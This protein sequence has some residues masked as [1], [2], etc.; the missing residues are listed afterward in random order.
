MV[1]KLIRASHLKRHIRETVCVAKAAPVVERIA[2]SVELLLEPR[3]TINYILG[4]PADD[5]YQF[6]SEKK[7]L[8]RAATVR[9]MINTIHAPDSS[10]AVQSIDDPYPFPPLTHLRSLLYTIMHLY[11]LYVS[12]ILMCTEYWLILVARLICCNCPHSGR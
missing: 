3:L 2:A 5:Q 12:M 1:E 8:L 6:K 9:A 4:G 10:R 7:R 11:L